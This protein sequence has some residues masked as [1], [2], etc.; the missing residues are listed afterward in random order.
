MSILRNKLKAPSELY[1]YMPVARSSFFFD[2]LI[3]FTQPS[4]LNDPFEMRPHITGYGSDA[5]MFEIANRRWE[6]SVR[7]EFELF[8]SNRD[9]SLKPVDFETYRERLESSRLKEVQAALTRAPEYNSKMV[10]HIN[11]MIEINVGVLSLCERP[12]IGLMWSHY[13]E[14]HFGFAV[15]FDTSASFFNQLTPPA[16]V[17]ATIE[18]T[19]AF[20]REYGRLRFVDYRADRPSVSVTEM[21]FDILMTK[22]ID[23]AYEREWRMLMPPIYANVCAQDNKGMPIHLF[24]IPA[25]AIKAVLLGC[26]SEQDLIDKAIALKNHAETEHIQ[27]KKAKVDERLFQINFE[28]LS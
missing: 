5:E 15:E 3:R 10:E 23:W 14:S 7:K 17:T 20:T 21:S 27:I 11:Q 6:E 12:D 25:N 1:K 28:E 8:C 26:N 22:G 9:K 24:E 16:H 13:G 2:R 18:D 19:E 4:A